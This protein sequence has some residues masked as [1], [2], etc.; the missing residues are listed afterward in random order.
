VELRRNIQKRGKRERTILE[1]WMRHGK[2]G[3]LVPTALI[4]EKVEVDT[5]GTPA[6]VGNAMTAETTLGAK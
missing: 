4:P 5:A 2:L 1:L 3:G 6:F